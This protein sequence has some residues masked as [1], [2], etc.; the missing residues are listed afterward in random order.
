MGGMGGRRRLEPTIG[1]NS[2]AARD[3]DVCE[4]SPQRTHFA[5]AESAIRWPASSR[6]ARSRC[7]AAS[8][9]TAASK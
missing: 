6:P 3:D 5:G 7:H 9:A 1:K 4:S 8:E 2:P